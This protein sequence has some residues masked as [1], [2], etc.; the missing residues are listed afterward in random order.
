M[1]QSCSSSGD[2]SNNTDDSTSVLCKK[3]ITINPD[4]NTT[5][6][7]SY[8]GNKIVKTEVF[9]NDNYVYK[10][11]YTYNGNLIVKKE[12][13]DEVNGLFYRVIF[14]Y[15]SNNLL[16]SSTRSSPFQNTSYR[17]VY[18]HNNNTISYML[19]QG[20]VNGQNYTPYA[21]G[22]ITMSNNNIRSISEHEFGSNNETVNGNRT[23][24]YDNMNNPFK[25]ILGL[26]K[27]YFEHMGDFWFYGS[28]GF[29]NNIIKQTMGN[30]SGSNI[31]YT[32][33]SFNY[34]TFSNSVEYTD[35]TVQY[36]Y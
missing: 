14:T 5:S 7:Y 8:N 11:V 24:N 23:Y 35:E 2:S 13:F 34:P 25:N 15:D 29:V 30:G 26:N 28:N 31:N 16:A 22:L 27:L 17:D 10:D 6:Y 12:S 3:T 1:L 32:Y 21:E 9:R 20:D 18:T 4:G 19:L 36:F 33:N